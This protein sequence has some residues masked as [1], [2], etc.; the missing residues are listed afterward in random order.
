MCRSCAGLSSLSK[1]TTSTAELRAFRRQLVEL[2]AADERCRV[3]GGPLLDHL[4]DDVAPAASARPSSSSSECSASS[5]FDRRS[6]RPTSAARSRGSLPREDAIYLEN[7]STRSH[8]ITPARTSNGASPQASTMVDGSPAG[9]GPASISTSMPSPNDAATRSGVAAG[10]SPG[11]IRAG[12][13]DRVARSSR[14][15]PR[16]GVPG[17]RTATRPVDR[18]TS[19]HKRE[20][21]GMMSVSGPGHPR[22]AMR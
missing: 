20:D 9:V 14:Q 5:F 4:H 16:D 1:M 7:S 3:R 6:A 2:A 22:D 13:R 12:R 8:G 21:A 10:G 18:W 17:T 11:D 19:L 15:R